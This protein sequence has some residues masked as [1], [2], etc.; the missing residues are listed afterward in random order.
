MF[1]KTI[2]LFIVTLL[3]SFSL[4]SVVFADNPT[5]DIPDTAIAAGNFSILVQALQKAEL[6]DALKGNGPFTVFAPTDDAFA[7][8]LSELGITAAELL[9][10]PALSDILLYHVVAGKIMSTDLVNG[11]QAETLNGQELEISLNPVK[12]NSSN[13]VAADIE[14]TNGVI[15]V[16]DKVLLPPAT[17]EEA[18][19][20]P[21]TAIDAG[22]F[23]ILVQA[24]I[25]ADLVDAL[26]GDG[27]FTVFAPTDDAFAALLRE[28]GIS[29][30]EL[31]DSP[32]LSDILLYHVVSGKI[33]S[34]DLSDGLEATAL[35]GGKL[36]IS[37]NPVMVNHS[38]VV[39]ADIE[40]SN[41]VIHVIDKVLLPQSDSDEKI[42]ENPKTGSPSV[43]PYLGLFI[44]SLGGLTLMKKTKK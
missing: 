29:A 2:A 11:M 33:M 3:I 4:S 1:K 40:T 5:M 30:A 28:L 25:K 10:N 14:A 39:A 32:Q 15:H 7:D 8:L 37:L 13:V 34:T 20:I 44:V 21:E 27:P 19:D 17:L 43:I 38:N 6:V 18:K 12:I 9:D 16:I 35:N 24:L 36:K 31:L 22:S 26:K 23:T 41:G 42:V